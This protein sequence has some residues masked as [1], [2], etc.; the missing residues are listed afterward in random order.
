MNNKCMRILHTSDWHLGARLCDRDRADEHQAFLQWLLN[1]LKEEKIDLLLIAGDVFDTSNPPNYAETIYYDFLCSV[2]ETGCGSVII[3]GG[4]HDSVSKLNSPRSLLQRMSVHVI[5]GAEEEPG[6][7]VYPIN[8]DSGTLK[9]VVCAV[10]FLRERDVRV[11]VPGESWDERESSMAEGINQYYKDVYEAAQELIQD[12]DVPLIAMG[13]LFVRGSRTGTGERDLYVGNLGSISSDIFPD[14][15]S[16]TALGHIH[17]PQ[18]ISQS[19]KIRY[20]GSPLFMDFGEKGSKTVLI[21]DFDGSE[22]S[23]VRDLEIPQFRQLIRFSGTVDDVLS[24][25]D[26][27]E[28]PKDPFWADAEIEG[29]SAVG[30]ISLLLNEKTAEKDFELLRIRILPKEGENVF[31]QTEV[32]EIQDLDAM[33]VFKERCRTG[34]MD[35]EEIDELTPLYEELLVKIH[36]D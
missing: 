22:L 12:Q 25:I 5:G 15:L 28:P 20:S 36:E 26:N 29:G 32:F 30:D 33:E 35:Q 9:T 17:K 24:Q 2:R 4:N 18:K 34:G 16:Y 3:I 19:E 6:K 10:P 8:D 21:A 23:S 1:I 27:F 13:H 31:Q 11:P 14:E 7:C